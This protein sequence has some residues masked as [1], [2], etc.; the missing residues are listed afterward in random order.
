MISSNQWQ[1]KRNTRWMYWDVFS[2]TP[3]ISHSHLLEVFTPWE[4]QLCL[5]DWFYMIEK[6]EAWLATWVERDACNL[7]DIFA[8]WHKNLLCNMQPELLYPCFSWGNLSGIHQIEQ[9]PQ[10]KQVVHINRIVNHVDYRM[11]CICVCRC[12]F[13]FCEFAV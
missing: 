13:W 7:M 9:S 5:S 12:M 8:D 3:C 6:W 1:T 10:L 4:C 2:T 11:L